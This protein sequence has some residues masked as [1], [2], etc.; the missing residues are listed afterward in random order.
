MKIYLAAGWFSPKQLALVEALETVFSEHDLF[1]PRSEGALGGK[2]KEEREALAPVFFES[3][4]K[5]IEDSDLVFAV[6]DDRDLGVVWEIGYAHGVGVP[7]VTFSNEG[8]GLNLM[9]AQCAERHVQGLEEA[10]DFADLAKTDPI[11]AMTG[12]KGESVT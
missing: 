10:G 8:H 1:S 9:I 2:T 11:Y 6:V 12:D 4:C 5:H 7:I 3:N